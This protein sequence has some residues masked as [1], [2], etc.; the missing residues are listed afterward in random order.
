MF[1][2]SP[3]VRNPSECEPSIDCTIS[4]IANRSLFAKRDGPQIGQKEESEA[5]LSCEF[6]LLLNEDGAEEKNP[7]LSGK[8]IRCWQAAQRPGSILQR[9]KDDRR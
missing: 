6:G 2:K 5:C 9:R 8:R 1:S 4:L 7:C 3:T